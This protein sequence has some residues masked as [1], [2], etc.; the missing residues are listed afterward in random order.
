MILQALKNNYI[1]FD[2]DIY[3]ILLGGK[4]LE[5]DISYRILCK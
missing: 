1:D 4:I 3:V 5:L 2:S